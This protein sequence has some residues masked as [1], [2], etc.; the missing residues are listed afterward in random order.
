[1]SSCSRKREKALESM[2]CPLEEH[3]QATVE[4]AFLLPVL[5][6]VLG[7]FLQPAFLLYNRCVMYAAAAEGCRLVATASADEGA[8]K[9]YVQ[10]RLR[11]VPRLSAFHEGGD[12]AWE[13][14]LAGGQTGGEVSVSIVNHARPLPFFG[15]GAGLVG[16]MDGDGVRQ[17]VRVALHVVPQWVADAGSGPADWIGRWS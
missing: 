13:I 1:M 6:L 2:P 9:A 12:D 5:F 16:Q 15:I 8:L 4:A 3:G 10:R 14:A 17:E 7:L 11:A